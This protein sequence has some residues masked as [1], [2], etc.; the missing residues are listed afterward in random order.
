M[1]IISPWFGNIW[2]NGQAVWFSVLTC[3]G[4][5]IYRLGLSHIVVPISI[6]IWRVQIQYKSNILFWAWLYWTGVLGCRLSGHHIVFMWVYRNS[7]A[8]AAE[9]GRQLDFSVAVFLC[10]WIPVH[11]NAHAQSMWCIA[12]IMWYNPYWL[13]IVYLCSGFL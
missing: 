11:V 5:E 9:E 12:W 7:V 8:A 3:V 10:A 1:L 2:E 13:C 6:W 4:L